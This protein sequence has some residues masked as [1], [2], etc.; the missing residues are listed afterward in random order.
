MLE[1]ECYLLP[2][3]NNDDKISYLIGIFYNN[4][5]EI[6]FKDKDYND[7]INSNQTITNGYYLYIH[8][9]DKP[10]YKERKY[11]CIGFPSSNNYLI[12]DLPYS[13]QITQFTNTIGLSHLYSPQLNGT[14]NYT[15]R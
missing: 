14:K 10:L 12:D 13:L 8:Y 2:D 5:A 7:I 11:I 3:N 9:H 6:I 15:K 1:K 4:V